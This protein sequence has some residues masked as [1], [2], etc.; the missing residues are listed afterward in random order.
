[1]DFGQVL[2]ALLPKHLGRLACALV[3]VSLAR[4]RFEALLPFLQNPWR[5]GL[6]LQ[7]GMA[8][9]VFSLPDGAFSLVFV[10]L[11]PENKRKT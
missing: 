2:N 6:P 8:V 4:V 9:L 5:T 1:M 3:T 7:V 10:P 11:H